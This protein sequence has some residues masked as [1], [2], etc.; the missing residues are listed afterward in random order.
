MANKKISE[1]KVNFTEEVSKVIDKLNDNV[2][3][4]S[5]IAD[6]G[7]LSEV[8]AAYDKARD[9][10][11]TAK[12][13]YMMNDKI[14]QEWQRQ[15]MRFALYDM[16]MQYYRKATTANNCLEWVDDHGTM[17]GNELSF[18][19]ASAERN[20]RNVFQ[21]YV[22]AHEEKDKVVRKK[23]SKAERVAAMRAEA[24]RLLAE[25]DKAE[26]EDK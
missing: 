9:A 20:A 10:Y 13:E 11:Q 21:S 8:R 1:I 18:S 19:V 6:K 25:A 14:M 22:D 23:T 15:I 16:A 5:N 12:F 4:E 24:A 17:L 26:K 2:T 7:A 3:Y